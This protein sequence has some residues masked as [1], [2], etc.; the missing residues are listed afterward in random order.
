MASDCGDPD[1][2]PPQEAA[3][4]STVRVAFGDGGEMDARAAERESLSGAHEPSDCP[5]ESLRPGLVAA[6]LLV[7]CV[8]LSV[9]TPPFQAPDEARHVMRGYQIAHGTLMPSLEGRRRRGGLV[10]TGLVELAGI[11]RPMAG[12][13]AVKES[14]DRWTD[15]LS[16][17][18]TG[19][20]SP[21]RFGTQESGPLI[22]APIAIGL[23]AGEALGLRP[24]AAYHLARALVIAL[25]CTIVWFSCRLC[26]PTPVVAALLL[27]P[28]SVFLMSTAV[29]DGTS[30]SCAA[31]AC[32]AFVRCTRDRERTG[33]RTLLVMAIAILVSVSGR[34]HGAPLLAL[35]PL[36]FAYTRRVSA[37]W[38]GAAM[39]IIIAGWLGLALADGAALGDAPANATRTVHVLAEDVAHAGTAVESVIRTVTSWKWI[40]GQY[41]MWVGDLGSLDTPLGTPAYITIGILLLAALACAVQWRPLRQ[42]PASAATLLLCGVASAAIVVIAL[43]LFYNGPSSPRVNGI[44]GRY[45][46]VPA[47][48]LAY[49]TVAGPTD[50]LRWQSRYGGAV[51]WT[52]FAVALLASMNALL[53]RY[54]GVGIG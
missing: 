25:N 19:A 3:R 53:R 24:L 14:G 49:S 20:S 39:L 30:I 47:L 8:V 54:Y 18:W 7:S 16:T 9:A 37:L 15:S 35:M 29:I 36:S 48:I 50:R 22:Y 5:M 10:D 32:A 33:W 13:A 34:P 27:L 11:W 23:G 4:G 12:D 52:I 26:R 17:R 6:L 51:V 38:I 43:K 2:A 45:F 44:Q 46:L 40:V 42:T 28:M 31:L 21:Q 1:Q 41:K